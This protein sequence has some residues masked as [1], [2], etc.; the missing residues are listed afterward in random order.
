MSPSIFNSWNANANEWNVHDTGE[1]N[2]WGNVNSTAPGVRQILT[3]SLKLIKVYF[4]EVK[5]K[6]SPW[7][8]PKNK[9][10]THYFRK[11]KMLLLF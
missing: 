6:I 9:K 4:K 2:Q 8:L 10:Q 1:L 5:N 11:N 7:C 3:K